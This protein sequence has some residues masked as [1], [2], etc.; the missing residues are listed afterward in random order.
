MEGIK[1]QILCR[2]SISKINKL[3]FGGAKRVAEAK[4]GGGGAT[5][6]GEG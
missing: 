5:P 2:L 1:V 6:D 4:Q 3:D